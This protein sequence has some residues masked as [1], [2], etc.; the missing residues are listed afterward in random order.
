MQVTQAREITGGLSHPSKMPSASY[1]IECPKWGTR[2]ECKHCY[3]RKGFYCMP[4]VAATLARR[5]RATCHSRWIEAMATLIDH[6][7]SA[8]GYFRWHDAGDLR[9]V[10]H[11]A[12][13]VEVARLTPHIKHWL[14]TQAP[15]LVS[16]FKRSGG[17]IPVN[18]IVRVS[19]GAVDTAPTRHRNTSTIHTDG[20]WVQWG[21]KCPAPTTDGH[22]ADCRACWDRTVPNVSYQLH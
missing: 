22:C 13:I 3:A 18:L 11:L 10:G 17:R 16:A 7:C 8:V 19:S 9:G 14:P 4:E 5:T 2:S 12:R 15:H 1:G 20:V 6:E 21:V